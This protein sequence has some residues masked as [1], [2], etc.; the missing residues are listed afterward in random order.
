MTTP[1]QAYRR[2]VLN[3]IRALALIL[4]LVASLI[5]VLAVFSV[6]VG[7]GDYSMSAI[8]LLILLI[9]LAVGV[10]KVSNV[11]LRALPRPEAP[12]VS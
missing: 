6:V 12:K 4:V 10:W 7:N 5:L 9:L 3:L 8:P 1:M 2:L 11:G